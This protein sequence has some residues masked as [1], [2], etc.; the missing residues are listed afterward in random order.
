[1]SEFYRF[2]Q[3]ELTALVMVA[4][5]CIVLQT[6]TVSYSLRRLSGSW[7]RRV[8]NGMEC[9]ILAGLFLFTALLGEVQYGLYGN[10]LMPSSYGTIRQVVFL[11]VAGLGAAAAVGTELIWPF[12]AIGGV[13]VLLPLAEEVTGPAY[14]AFFLTALFYFLIRSVH[15]CMIRRRELY[16]QITSVSIKE[17]IDSLQTGLLFFRPEGDILLCN[18]QMDELSRLLTGQCVHNG[19][20]FQSSL[21]TGVLHNNCIRESL[22]DQKVFRLPDASVWCITSHTIPMGHKNCILLSADNITVQWDAVRQLDEQNQALEKRGQE[23]RDTIE[24]LQSICEAEE[25]ARSKG[26]V[27]DLMGQRIS[28]LLRALRD[29]QQP[30]EALLLDFARSLPTIMREDP[31]PSPATRLE[32]L[33]KTFRSMDVFVEIQGELPEDR[34][35]ADSFVEIA[36]EC[37]TNAVRHAYAT[38]VQFYFFQNDHWRMTVTDNGIPPTGSIR[39]GGGIGGMRRRIA[40]LGGVMELYSV[41]RFRI[42]LSVPKEVER[43]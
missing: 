19:R 16:T 20:E 23:L 4:S 31:T 30:D 17:A 26:R 18:R 42:E 24:H 34:T 35:V 41:P 40:Q 22:G 11:L 10:F 36:V 8:E 2:P 6:L 21:E 25:I 13:S 38:R 33:Q 14:P 9:A 32:M 15:L 27:H 39:E 12:F 3:W 1:M 29:S 37:V 43:R 7:S 28:L 5:V